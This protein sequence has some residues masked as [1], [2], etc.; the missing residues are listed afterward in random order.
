V[1]P[2]KKLKPRCTSQVVPEAQ[3]KETRNH[4]AATQVINANSADNYK[5]PK[6][7]N[8]A[9]S[10][11]MTLQQLATYLCIPRSTIYRL[12]QTGRLPAF[13]VGRQWRVSLKAVQNYLLQNYEQK[14][15]QKGS[16]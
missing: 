1:V 7:E 12:V 5:I 16:S 14:T 3:R 15:G 11:V 2:K 10:E 6:V 4:P 9:G 8:I 13:K